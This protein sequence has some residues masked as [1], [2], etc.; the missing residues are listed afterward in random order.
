M[1]RI[2]IALLRGVCQT[3]AYVAHSRGYFTEEGLDV[4]LTV[5]PTAWLIP[6]ELLAGRRH[7]G[8]IPWTRV[9]AAERGE[10]PLKV[11]CG[12]GHEEAALVVRAGLDPAQVRTVA[13]PREGGIKDLTAMGL[14]ATMGWES[15]RQLRF[16][17]GDGAILAFVGQAADAA[18][19]IEPYATMLETLGLG[20]VV[21]RTGDLWKGAPGCALSAAADYV[22]E[23]P[24]ITQRV[25]NAF[26]RGAAAVASDPEGAA[27]A[28]EPWIGVR[29]D[30]I[31]RALRA[32]RPDCDAVRNE[33]PMKRIL[34]LMQDLGYTRAQPRDFRD[35]RF[36]E[37]AQERFG[38]VTQAR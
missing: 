30:I 11:L 33:E 26:V 34:G 9:A 8:V 6:D 5:S 7:F 22:R 17:S 3:P 18:S 37:R 29:A 19:M 12:S 4:E 21:R 35:L 2:S 1:D 13:V 24:E 14:I 31:E 16:P 38:T 27:A 28:A 10:A 32:N 25:V 20:V 15:A 23:Q 36:L